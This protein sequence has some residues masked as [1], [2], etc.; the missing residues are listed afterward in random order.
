MIVE[1]YKD[2]K[3]LT[4]GLL[5]V[6]V[7]LVA[8]AARAG[9]EGLPAKASLVQARASARSWRADALLIRINSTAVIADGTSSIWSYGFY[10]SA[11]KNCFVVTVANGKTID[12]TESGGAT[13]EE[14]ELVDFMDSGRAMQIARRNGIKTSA[15][16]MGLMNTPTPEGIRA[17]W[18]VYDGLGARDASVTID[19]G[20]GAVLERRP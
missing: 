19:A 17:T 6:A 16:T 10:S 2:L 12:T 4:T 9:A 15:T 1:E 5:V 11:A 18:I 13:C 14:P 8:A 3:Q 7:A 20:T